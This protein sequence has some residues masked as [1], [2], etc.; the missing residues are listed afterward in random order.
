MTD[1]TIHVKML[2]T[3]SIECAGG[4]VDDNSNRMRKI[5]LLLA[6][7][8]YNRDTH[9]P[10]E[11]YLSL[12]SKKGEEQADPL[13]SLKA[14][15]YRARTLLDSA[16]KTLGRDVIVRK[17]GS[18]AWNTDI[19]L[20]LD[21]DDFESLCRKCAMDEDKS[22]Q[23]E[24]GLMALDIYEGD[25]LSKLSSEPWVMPIAEY[26][27]R[28]YVNTVVTTLSLLEE[29]GNVD[30]MVEV[31]EKALSIEPY[32][33][34]LYRYLMRAHLAMGNRDKALTV[35]EDMS[36]LLFSTFGVMPSDESRSL[37]REASR[38]APGVSVSA[39]ELRESLK[40]EKEISGA[41]YCEYDF[42]RVLYQAQARALERSGDVIH[43]ALLSIHQKGSKEVSRR[44]IDI[45]MDNLKE[46]VLSNLRQGDIVTKCSAT[47]LIVMLPQANYENSCMVCD[48]LVKAFFRQYPHSPID[49]HQSVSPLEPVDRPSQKTDK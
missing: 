6:Y 36:E 43:I 25:F 26:Y 2:G 31:S 29:S 27:H 15:F 13:G 5:W 45:A 14:L 22:L 12:V 7:M 46:I 11:S 4:A 44:S 16:H 47:Q 8:I 24:S 49:I 28:L 18:Y 35:Y 33:E 1:N 32:E 37:Y 9:I 10:Q 3:F 30:K 39:G 48:R 20:K 17:N 38:S 34:V 19:P 21:V 40:E 41:L 42:F 23:L